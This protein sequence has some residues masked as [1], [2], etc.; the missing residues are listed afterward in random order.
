MNATCLVLLLIKENSKSSDYLQSSVH[1]HTHIR[2][3]HIPNGIW[4]ET[5]HC[6]NRCL[7]RPWCELIPKFT[8]DLSLILWIS[9]NGSNNS[10]KIQRILSLLLSVIRILLRGWSPFL[11]HKSLQSKEMSATLIRF[12]YARFLAWPF[13][14]PWL[15]DTT[16]SCWKYFQ[17]WGWKGRL[18]HQ[19]SHTV[20]LSIVERAA[21][22]SRA[23]LALWR[24]PEQNLWLAYQSLQLRSG[25]TRFGFDLPPWKNKCWLQLTI[26]QD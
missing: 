17:S 2:L 7:E 10:V 16:E 19:V 21:N 24:V 12:R 1:I 6:C 11:D 14:A 20:Q 5:G 18:A 8:H 22:F 13:P 9:L 15:N 3:I 26:V 23:M 4:I 25:K